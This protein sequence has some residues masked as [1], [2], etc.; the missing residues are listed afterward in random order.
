MVL[1]GEVVQKKFVDMHC[2]CL[3]SPETDKIVVLSVGEFQA[4]LDHMQKIGEVLLLSG[5]EY[6]TKPEQSLEYQEPLLD[7]GKL[8]LT[9]VTMKEMVRTV[10]EHPNVLA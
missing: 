9:V 1:I 4:C 7:F 5:M 8:H 6:W 10:N 2:L 3:L